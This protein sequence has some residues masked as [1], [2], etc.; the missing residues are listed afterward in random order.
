M[1]MMTVM[2]AVSYP[3]SAACSGH[4]DTK[5]TQGNTSGTGQKTE[6]G[7]V[8][9][10]R[11]AATPPWTATV[12]NKM[13][14]RQHALLTQESSSM[15]AQKTDRKLWSGRV[16]NPSIL[17]QA[18]W[19]ASCLLQHY[20]DQPKKQEQ[21]EH[22]CCAVASS[23]GLVE[24]RNWFVCLSTHPQ[25]Q[26]AQR[27]SLGYAGTTPGTTTWGR[28]QRLSSYSAGLTS[29]AQYWCNSLYSK[30]PPPPPPHPLPGSRRPRFSSRDN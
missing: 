25:T 2:C 17:H 10:E 8:G 3:R 13:R 30:S 26:C 22:M 4:K 27:S 16:T 14:R 23:Q 19:T 11:P 1:T 12:R 5:K 18:F 7:K 24:G 21:E 29:Q 28:W 9:G 15:A 20:T 6:K